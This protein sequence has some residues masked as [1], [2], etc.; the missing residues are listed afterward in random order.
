M[1]SVLTM[2]CLVLTVQP[3][4]NGR[5]VALH[6]LAGHIRPGALGALGDFIE[7]VDKDNA[8]LLGFCLGL[9]A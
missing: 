5:Q 4:I 7:F 3:S 8:V 2:P 9:S 6:A 1:W